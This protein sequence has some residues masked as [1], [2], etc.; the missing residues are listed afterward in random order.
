[1]NVDRYNLRKVILEEYKQFEEGFRSAEGVFVEGKF[2]RIMISGM[3]G[4]S[5]PGDILRIFLDTVWKT[6]NG[7][8]IGV[9]QNRFY[10]LPSQAYNRCL[11]FVCSHSGNTE[12][13]IASLEEAIEK[14]LPTVGIAS[15]G[16]VEKICKAEGIPFVKLPIPFEYFQPRM[17]TGHFISAL[18]AVLVKSEMLMDERKDFLACAAILKKKIK[19]LESQGRDIAQSLVGKTPIIYSNDRYRALALTWKIKINENAK[20]PAF[21][22]YLPEMNHNEMVGFTNPQAQFRAVMLRDTEDDPR[23]LKRYE[24]TARLLGE[25]GVETQILDIPGDTVYDRVFLTLSLGDW[26]SYYLALEYG[27]D[28]TPVNMVEDFKRMLKE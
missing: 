6:R 18:Y 23:N 22:N 20:T 24:N 2:D 16:R 28:P 4:S 14:K 17:A 26:I 9:Y 10:T 12:E 15:G 11:N 21:W 19:T 13:T 1:M 8:D 3:G 5:W 27:I 25:R 7:R